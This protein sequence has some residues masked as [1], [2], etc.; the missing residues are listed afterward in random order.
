MA[1]A[2]TIY[3]DVPVV[4]Q[5]KCWHVHKIKGINHNDFT[6]DYGD[7]PIVTFNEITKKFEDVVNNRG[8]GYAARK[9]KCYRKNN[10]DIS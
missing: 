3:K 9:R 8:Y 1:E 4:I 5:H 7:I 10:K 6:E 2:F